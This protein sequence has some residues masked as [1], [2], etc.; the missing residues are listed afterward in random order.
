MQIITSGSERYD[1]RASLLQLLPQV[2]PGSLKC[3]RLEAL[4]PQVALQIGGVDTTPLAGI[5]SALNLPGV[6]G[7]RLPLL[8]LPVLHD[9]G[10]AGGAASLLVLLYEWDIQPQAGL[11]GRERKRPQTQ[12]HDRP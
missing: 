12:A 3:K 11:R 4:L 2:F 9:H 8:S 5:E 6:C 7:G 10:H 1:Q